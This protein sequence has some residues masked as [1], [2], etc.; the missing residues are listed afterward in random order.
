MS[1]RSLEM[2]YYFQAA[3]LPAFT[4]LFLFSPLGWIL[5]THRQILSLKQKF[6]HLRT[7]LVD[8][9]TKA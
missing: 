2:L 5:N 7:D 9:R 8:I 1:N 6:L 4:A 3:V